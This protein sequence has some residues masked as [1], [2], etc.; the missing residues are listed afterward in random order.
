MSNCFYR[1][2]I[3]T[4]GFF[5]ESW[6]FPELEQWATFKEENILNKK[7]IQDN[8][9]TGLFFKTPLLFFRNSNFNR[10]TAHI[11]VVYEP[12]PTLSIVPGAL[13]FIVG[14]KDSYMT[15]YELPEGPV[16]IQETMAKTP[17]AE[18]DKKDLK[19]IERY[20]IKEGE[21]VLVR[22]DVPHSIEMNTDNRW[23]ISL[24][25]RRNKSI[26]NWNDLVNFLENKELL[27]KF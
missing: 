11:D 15:W 5:N 20:K 14:G 26:V 25:L 21:L 6:K 7:W 2:T 1:T 9:K 4:D 8:E 10:D 13:N 3:S 17:F 23:C 19:E 18:W 27:I 16:N 12:A 24:R 22:T